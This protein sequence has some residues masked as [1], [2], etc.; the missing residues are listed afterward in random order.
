MSVQSQAG[1]LR[2]PSL[3]QQEIQTIHSE[4]YALTEVTLCYFTLSKLSTTRYTTI[5]TGLHLLIRIAL[6]PV[7]LYQNSITT[8]QIDIE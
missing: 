8:G 5:L 2:R 6:Q 1:A 7:E 3:D 4:C